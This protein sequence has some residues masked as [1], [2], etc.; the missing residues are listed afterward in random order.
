M[1]CEDVEDHR[2]AVHHLDVG[3]I[4]QGTPL[5]RRQVGVHDDRVRVVRGDD[6]RYLTRLAGTHI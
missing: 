4:L 3:Q 5:A 1:L 2:G 6:V